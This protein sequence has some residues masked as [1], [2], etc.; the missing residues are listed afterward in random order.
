MLLFTS[1]KLETNFFNIQIPLHNLFQYL[2]Y[3][4]LYNIDSDLSSEHAREFSA[5]TETDGTT[6]TF[7][8][9]GIL[10]TMCHLITHTI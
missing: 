3:Q 7:C 1:G 8:T 9:P 4:G 5:Q 2:L 6:G 10:W